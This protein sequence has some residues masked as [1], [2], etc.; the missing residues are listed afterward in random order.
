MKQKLQR[1]GL[2]IYQQLRVKELAAPDK[3]VSELAKE[4]N[5]PYSKV[6]FFVISTNL[7]CLLKSTSILKQRYEGEKLTGSKKFNVNAVQNWLV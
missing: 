4:I 5:A 6:Y 3:T 7:P 2:T 1:K